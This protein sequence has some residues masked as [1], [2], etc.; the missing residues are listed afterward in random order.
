MLQRYALV[1][2]RLFLGITFAIAVWP[3][4]HAGAAYAGILQGFLENFALPKAAPFYQSFLNGVVIPHIGVFAGLI[5]A[6]ETCVAIAFITGTATRVAGIVA[7]L[8]VTNYMLSK[9]MWWWYPASNDA[10]DFMIALA[11]VIGAAGRTLGVDAW[12]HA[13]FP[14][15]PF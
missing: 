2:L 9:G 15:G 10:A 11:L 5:V 8:L 12:L 14:R 4:I 6:G 7:M 1:V 13:R 3:K